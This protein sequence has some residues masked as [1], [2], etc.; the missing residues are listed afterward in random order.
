[1][2]ELIFYRK[3]APRNQANS[4]SSKYQQQ[5]YV[6]YGSVA[7]NNNDGTCNVLLNKGFET[8]VRIP[9]ATW[10]NEDP[11]T[12]GISYPPV[13]AQVMIFAPENDLASGYVYP[14]YLNTRNSDV[15]IALLD[16]GDIT[17]LPGGWTH[18]YDQE[19]GKTE[20]THG[21]TFD[22]IVDP[23]TKIVSL[24]DFEG[25]TFKNNGALWEINGTTE[26]ARLGDTAKITLSAID[27][28]AL[29]TALLTTLAFT[30]TGSVPI[31]ATVPVP[32]IVDGEITSGSSKVKVG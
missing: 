10:A 13:G 3:P 17:I 16:Q 22:L 31:A 11:V 28:Q 26:V 23:D 20:F 12:G 30:P 9:A 6:S 8:R 21:D 19:T 14:S 32:A 15:E 29:A 4:Q 1:M 7:S 27:V 2:K 5:I 24:T 18:T 25:N